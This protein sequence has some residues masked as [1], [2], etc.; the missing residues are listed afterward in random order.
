MKRSLWVSA[1]LGAAAG[2]RGAQPLAW[3]ARDL[4]GRRLPRGASA[5][6]RAFADDRVARTLA[7]I[8]AAELA[9]DKLR[10]TPDRVAPLP[11]LGR[12]ASG[13]L[14][15]ALG[16]GRDRQLAGALLGAGTAVAASWLAWKVR[17]EVARATM[18][19]D[20]AVALAEDALAVVAA[21]EL[22]RDT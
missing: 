13:A 12:A 6:E 1:G 20:A 5:L 22:V 4:T 10:I 3:I 16:A 11:L 18:L 15:G 19:P 8:A 2:L 21:R 14:A 9:G 7:L 17:R